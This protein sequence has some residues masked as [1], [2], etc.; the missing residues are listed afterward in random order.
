MEFTR[1]DG[2]SNGAPQKFF[3]KNLPKCPLCGGAPHWALNINNTDTVKVFAQCGHCRGILFI[4]YITI[5]KNVN[6]IIYDVGAINLYSLKPNS[7][8]KV[9]ELNKLTVYN[10]QIP[11][12]QVD[13]GQEIRSKNNTSTALKSIGITISIAGIVLIF[14]IGF[15][16]AIY[17]IL[18][19]IT[20]FISG[21]ILKNQAE[22]TQMLMV[23][24][25]LND[26]NFKADIV[27]N[28]NSNISLLINNTLQQFI[29][30]ENRQYNHI[31]KFS[32]ILKIINEEVNIPNVNDVVCSKLSITIVFKDMSLSNYTLNFLDI[33]VSIQTSYYK[34]HKKLYDEFYETLSKIQYIGQ[35]NE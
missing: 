7:V 27:L 12:H 16:Y 25:H 21:S 18:L 31:Y 20:L 29:L 30:L 33:S 6:V 32:D 4:D 13:L 1:F 5:S 22:N 23:K 28:L 10:G 34:Q 9:S 17:F 14:I 8:Y 3:D 26:I 19:G 24:Q 35:Q 15:L 11:I 2:I